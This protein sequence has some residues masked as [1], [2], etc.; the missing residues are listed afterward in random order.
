MV[1]TIVGLRHAVSFPIKW[2]QIEL[3]HERASTCNT[4][5]VHLKDTFVTECSM[6]LNPI[7]ILDEH[8]SS[9]SNYAKIVFDDFECFP[10]SAHSLASKSVQMFLHRLQ[11]LLGQFLL[12]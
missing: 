7:T 9:L 10:M 1:L 5:F 11:K 8:I 4:N 6:M 3:Y 12:F 2:W